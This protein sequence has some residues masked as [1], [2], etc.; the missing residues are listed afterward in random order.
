MLVVIGKEVRGGYARKAKP[1]EDRRSTIVDTSLDQT[2]RR[3]EN[4]RVV[5]LFTHHSSAVEPFPLPGSLNSSLA[6]ATEIRSL[7]KYNT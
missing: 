6:K 7:W 1:R 4:S 2:L 5:C 3:W